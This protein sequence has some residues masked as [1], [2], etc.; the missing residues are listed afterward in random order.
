MKRFSNHIYDDILYYCKH[1]KSSL[2]KIIEKYP[3]IDYQ[4][5]DFENLIKLIHYIL[6]NDYPTDGLIISLGESPS[7]MIDIQTKMK[8]TNS[9]FY[10]PISKTVLHL[11][12]QPFYKEMQQFE[13]LGQNW[14]IFF[15]SFVQTDNIYLQKYISFLKKRGIYNELFS[16]LSSHKKIVLVDF[17]MYG[18]SFVGFFL[19]IFLPFL[20]YH[21]LYD[22]EFYAIFIIS[23][24]NTHHRIGDA[25]R[26][27][28]E[29]YFISYKE[30]YLVDYFESKIAE[31]ISEYFMDNNIRC[32]QQ[33]NAPYY[34]IPQ[35]YPKKKDYLIL[36]IV[37]YMMILLQ[38]KLSK[39]F[40]F[41]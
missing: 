5:D 21:H 14:Q 39:Y 22:F 28:C 6:K 13:D 33:V 16:K 38:P 37:V 2:L 30:Y 34:Q 40:D 9:V 35:I 26:L 15:D 18:N 3:F 31:N 10:M 17:L 41:S 19:Y 27:L 36:L 23:P 11:D 32:I 1:R 12:L 29:T 24:Y 7:K 20:Y 4:S 25:L 8:M